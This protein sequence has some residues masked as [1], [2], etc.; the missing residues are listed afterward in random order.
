M[1]EEPINVNSLPISG[2]INQQV[3]DAIRRMQEREERLLK[4]RLENK[5]YTSPTPITG[6]RELHYTQMLEDIIYKFKKNIP[7]YR[8]STMKVLKYIFYDE[9]RSRWLSDC[10]GFELYGQLKSAFIRSLIDE[11]LSTIKTD[12]QVEMKSFVKLVLDAYGLEC[13]N[14]LSKNLN[15]SLSIINNIKID[16]MKKRISGNTTELF[17]DQ[18]FNDNFSFSSNWLHDSL[19][20]PASERFHTRSRIAPKAKSKLSSSYLWL[21]PEAK[22]LVKMTHSGEQLALKILLEVAVEFE[23]GYQTQHWKNEWLQLTY[24]RLL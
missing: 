19:K 16:V 14:I 7:Q 21:S 18:P 6:H 20:G 5:I 2:E 22:K 1:L 8:F 24:E 9:I 10:Y 3:V 15:L 11:M 13:H 17:K 23:P 12:G 4:W